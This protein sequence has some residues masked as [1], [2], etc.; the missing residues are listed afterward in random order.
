MIVLINFNTEFTI[1]NMKL[2]KKNPIL[3]EK[4][5]LLVRQKFPTGREKIL[6]S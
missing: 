1:Q 2:Q 3:R 4:N 5:S 6:T